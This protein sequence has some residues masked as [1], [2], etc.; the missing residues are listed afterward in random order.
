MQ[1]FDFCS[2]TELVFGR[3]VETE[4][5]TRLARRFPGGKVF[6]VYGGGSI[7]R[8]G[9][10]D[11][12]K[13]SLLDAGLSVREK[14]GVHP[15][16]E[17]GFI[18]ELIAEA[19]EWRPDVLLVV[20]GGSV[21]DTVKAASMGIPYDGDVWDFFIGR[22]VCEKATPISVILTIP[23]AGSE[24]SMRVVVTNGEK[25][26]G[27]ASQHI[28][29]FMSLID[30]EL[31][32]TLPAVQAASGVVDMMSHIMERYFTNT[33]D[34]GFIDGQAEAAMRSIMHFGRIIRRE[35][36][37]YSA[38]SQIGLAG[39]FAHN[40]F[41]GLGQ[42][43]DWACHGMEHALSGW[44]PSIIHAEGLAVIIPGYLAFVGV[45]N[46]K[47]VAQWARNVME[48]KEEDDAEAIR[49]GIARLKAF[50]REMGMPDSLTALG[51]GDAPL[52]ELA[53]SVT[54]GKTLG[55]F[56]PLEASDVLTIYRSVYQAEV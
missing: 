28:R 43:E 46:P 45:R 3:G 41:Y 9:L 47:R 37:N 34:T 1:N 12:V 56:V 26:L 51:A 38:W 13:Q 27:T 32:F 40:G 35:P 42:E 16:P 50:Y 20:G 49:E 53:Q 5:G 22:A 6:L 30:P 19:R 21:I 44:K 11:R 15:N 8:T 54:G 24:L 23:A 17:V 7:K 2:P 48:V 39:T 4:I 29:S 31:F 36:K 55:H 33:S 18:R 25:K 10:Y 14:G 52:E